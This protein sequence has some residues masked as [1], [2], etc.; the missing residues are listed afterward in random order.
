MAVESIYV[1]RDDTDNCSTALILCLS[2]LFCESKPMS[3]V[4]ADYILTKPRFDPPQVRMRYRLVC[5]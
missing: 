2:V 4:E 3:N 1:R 5:E